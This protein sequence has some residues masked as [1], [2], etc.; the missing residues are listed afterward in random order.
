MNHIVVD[1]AKEGLPFEVTLVVANQTV[2]SPELVSWL[3]ERAEDGPRRFVI[4]V[5]QD[6]GEGTA[7]REARERLR[8]LLRSLRAEKLVAGGMIGHPDPY[9]ATMNA[10]DFFHISEI[11]I[12]TLP[13]DRVEVGGRQAGRARAEGDVQARPARLVEHGDGG[14]LMEAGVLAP[15]RT[16]GPRRA[17][18]PRA[19][20]RPTAPRGWRRPCSGCCFSS[21]A[22]S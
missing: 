15:G 11:V 17:R 20:R 4:V 5:P 18:A 10:V 2:A 8:T 13:G 12:S 16:A 6:H 14:G 7:V 19:A 22:R 3:K 9:I 1:L 21:S